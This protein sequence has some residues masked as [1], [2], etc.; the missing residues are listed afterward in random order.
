MLQYAF[1]KYNFN[2]Q[3]LKPIFWVCK[4]KELSLKDI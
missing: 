2:P 4:M 1:Y 3:I